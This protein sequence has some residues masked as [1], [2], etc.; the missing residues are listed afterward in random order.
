MSDKFKKY[1]TLPLMLFA[2]LNVSSVGIPNTLLGIATVF[3]GIYAYHNRHEL[4]LQ[5]KDYYICIG[6]FLIAMLLSAF[7]S[8]D[9]ILGL[10]TWMG[11]WFERLVPFIII[12]FSITQAKTAKRMLSLAMIGMAFDILLVIY[13]GSQGMTRANGFFGHPMN[14]AGYVSIYMP[15]FLIYFLEMERMTKYYWT[16]ALIFLLGVIAL[17]FN[18]T[19]GAWIAVGICILA[20]L[21]CYI[22]EHKK[23]VTSCLIV[24]MILGVG[25]SQYKPFVQRAETITNTTTY[26]S[27]TERL[28]IWNSAWNMFKDHPILGV[29]LGQYAQNYHTKY[30]SPHAKEPTLTHAHN[31]LLQMLAENGI[32][33]FLSFVLLFGYFIVCPMRLFYKTKNPY[34]LMISV[35]TLGLMIQGLTEYNVG[36]P[37][38][39]RFYWLT[40]GCLLVLSKKWQESHS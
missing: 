6:I 10:K 33:G 28:L 25:F 30:I 34:A 23:L 5:Y 8:G 31:N 7:G 37:V 40:Q 22:K 16:C 29:G 12:T 11:K 24:L 21:F 38:V 9:I 13:Q 3:F 4:T 36:T 32:I 26:Q 19:R 2:L 27:N 39:M 15:I 17:A 1:Y 20:V 18:G 14:F 35:S